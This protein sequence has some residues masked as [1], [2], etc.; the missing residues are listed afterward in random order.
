MKL[1]E[2]MSVKLLTLVFAALQG[3]QWGLLLQFSLKLGSQILMFDQLQVVLERKVR[4][5]L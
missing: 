1:G 3:H 4:D 2:M 5:V